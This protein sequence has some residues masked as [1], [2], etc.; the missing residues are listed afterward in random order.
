MK[1]IQITEQ[2]QLVTVLVHY[3]KF[4][5]SFGIIL[6]CI[7]LIV[8]FIIPQIQQY[9]DQRA[10]VE[11]IQDRVAILNNNIS[12]LKR[13]NELEQNQQVLTV[14]DALSDDKD[15]SGILFAVRNASSKAG[16]GLGDFTFQVGEL[17]TKGVITQA[18]PTIQ[19]KL[20]VIGTP[21]EVGNFLRELSHTLPLSNVKEVTINSTSSQIVVEFYYKPLPQ[22]QINYAQPVV[23]INQTNRKI[24][25]QLQKWQSEQSDFDTFT[26]S[27]QASASASPFGL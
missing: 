4:Y 23:Q 1:Q 18:L 15:Y 14:L 11:E 8:I 12:Y 9:N 22:L 6:L 17:S 3:K 10:Q 26:P 19:I 5:I 7:V 24:L 27:T 20:N 21:Q 25:D 2:S 13:I 16:I